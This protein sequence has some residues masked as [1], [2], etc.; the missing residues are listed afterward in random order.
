[1]RLLLAE[2]DTQLRASLARG[3]R[4]VRYVVDVAV[5]GDEALSSAMMNEYDVI[6]LDVLM[7][8]RDGIEV[9]KQMRRRGNNTPVLLLTARAQVPDR[10]AGLDAGADDYLA[11]PFDFGELQARLRALVRRRDE[12]V[13][14]EFVIDNLVIDF[15]DHHARRGTREVRLTAREFTFLA[16]L[17]RNAGRIVTRAQ[18]SA[19]VW[20]DNH[21]PASNVLE[22]YVNRLRRKL[23]LPGERPLIHTRR[24][25]GYIFAVDPRG[26]AKS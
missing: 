10:I 6:V 8:K 22:V 11:K 23:E 20:D 25:A 1:M 26:A 4:E 19:H 12:I 14:E 2:D 15:R 9:C 13:P 18:I 7:P 24:G 3:L 5:D 21:D 16:F 17:A